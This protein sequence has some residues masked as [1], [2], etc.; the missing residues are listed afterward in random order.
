[1][2]NLG[3]IEM[4]GHEYP[5]SEYKRHTALIQR[6][7]AVA[8][9]GGCRGE[10]L[11]R[12]VDDRSPLPPRASLVALE[13]SAGAPGIVREV[14][15]RLRLRYADPGSESALAALLACTMSASGPIACD[16]ESLSV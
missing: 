16:P 11:L 5:G 6:A 15:G 4:A 9:A 1:M 8:M 7:E 3:A 2:V 10:T 12:D 14:A 13:R